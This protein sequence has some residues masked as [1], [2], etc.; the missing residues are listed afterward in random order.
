MVEITNIEN[1]KNK[2]KF[3]L[4]VDGQFYSGIMKETA[5]ANNFFVGK[6]IEKNVLDKILIESE[7][8]MAFGKASDLLATRL[9][10][11][12]ELKLKLIKKGFS[13]DAINLAI[14]KLEDY[15][16]INDAEFANLFVQSNSKL[17][18]QMLKNKLSTKGISSQIIDDVISSISADDEFEN[19]IRL[20]EKYLKN[21]NLD[22]CKDKLYAFLARKG[23]SHSVIKQ[24]ILRVANVD[25]DFD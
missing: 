25:V 2:D 15:G 14:N 8:K 13:K 23:F 10:S 22:E 12:D 20:A 11:K 24:T 6:K 4:F 3:N 9:H 17:S 7:S 21:K 18:K 16:Y 19:A 5:I 1:Q